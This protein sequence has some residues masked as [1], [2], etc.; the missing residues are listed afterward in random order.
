[1]SVLQIVQLRDRV[2]KKQT[3]IQSLLTTVA[4]MTEELNTKESELAE[5]TQRAVNAERKVDQLGGELLEAVERFDRLQDALKQNE[6][7]QAN[8]NERVL[9]LTKQ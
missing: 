6:N 9:Q 4:Q 7:T 1:M 8:T 3:Q 5:C 2:E